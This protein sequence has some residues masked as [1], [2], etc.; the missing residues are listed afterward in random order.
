MKLSDNPILETTIAHV[1]S[2]KQVKEIVIDR[3][4][5]PHKVTFVFTDDESAELPLTCEHQQFMEWWKHTC[6]YIEHIRS[7]QV[8]EIT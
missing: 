8:T 3:K 6:N 7:I 5:A 4:I 2:G 1:A